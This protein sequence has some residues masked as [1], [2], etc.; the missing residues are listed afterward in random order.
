M[1]WSPHRLVEILASWR[2]TVRR[3]MGQSLG[4]TPAHRQHADGDAG[5]ASY[6]AI[7]SEL[8]AR[9][10]GDEIESARALFD[11]SIRA[12][13]TC[14]ALLAVASAL[15]AVLGT[16]AGSVERT[17]R[18]LAPLGLTMALVTRW[19]VAWAGRIMMPLAAMLLPSVHDQMSAML[20]SAILL[21]GGSDALQTKLLGPFTL[22][23]Q[24]IAAMLVGWLMD[25]GASRRAGCMR[26]PRWCF[27]LLGS[28]VLLVGMAA[29]ERT[30][31]FGTSVNTMRS[32]AVRLILIFLWAA[33]VHQR[34]AH[35]GR[36]GLGDVST[37]FWTAM[38]RWRRR[39]LGRVV[40]MA[41]LAVTTVTLLNGFALPDSL[42][43]GGAN[44]AVRVT[45]ASGT[46]RR[47]EPVMYFWQR[48]GRLLRQA[49]FSVAGRHVFVVDSMSRELAE[50]Y[51][52][53]DAIAPRDGFET[54]KRKRY[55]DQLEELKPWRVG[56]AAE[57]ESALAR[58]ELAATSPRIWLLD[59]H[60]G[61][62]RRV[63]SWGGAA[64]PDGEALYIRE[65]L[66]ISLRSM[67]ET[68]I[69]K[70]EA[71]RPLAM[72]GTAV[73]AA[74]AFVVLWR[75]GGDAA[76]ALW[77]GLWLAGAAMLC[78]MPIVNFVFDSTLGNAANL[79][80]TGRR[81]LKNA[82]ELLYGWSLVLAILTYLGVPAWMAYSNLR[83]PTAQAVAATFWRRRGSGLLSGRMI[84]IGACAA[85]AV[86]GPKLASSPPESILIT[87]A[88]TLAGMFL[89]EAA[90]RKLSPPIAQKDRRLAIVP[91]VIF[92]F[93]AV[94]AIL[95]I[96]S[97][98]TQGTAAPLAIGSGIFA[99]VLFA[100]AAL[101]FFLRHD[102]LRMSAGR[103]LSWVATS[104]AL[105]AIFEIVNSWL[106]WLLDQLGIFLPGASEVASLVIVVALMQPIQRVLESWFLLISSRALR[107]IQERVDQILEQALS[108]PAAH[109]FATLLRGFFT[110]LGVTGYAL[111]LRRGALEFRC[112]INH[113]GVVEES[114]TLSDGLCRRLA[115]SRSVIDLETVHSEWVYFFDQFELH[116]LAT[117]TRGRYLCPVRFGKSLWGLLL[118]DDSAATR[119]IARDA[120]SPTASQ[121]GVAFSKWRQ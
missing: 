108:D 86:A 87:G 121:I 83:P 99:L 88:A 92:L 58:A 55:E 63:G 90:R 11:S 69:A 97:L 116:R 78:A 25:M 14:I 4:A 94:Q 18:D 44:A 13:W 120:F 34:F 8:S 93:A 5:L 53:W 42:A 76:A 91:A 95:Y 38:A 105:P 41:S 39:L 56:S 29:F 50:K 48:Q 60:P 9:L 35:G 31:P 2:V 89:I 61:D 107:K 102:W 19:R 21:T 20:V 40:A 111:W 114:L 36:Y 24:L 106:P 47:S 117:R 26:R 80:A 54:F 51:R 109:D 7:Q 70:L 68:S 74:L 101:V 67:T 71:I 45:V 49:D 104:F 23:L 16:S 6:P 52:I 37:L 3:V 10:S 12:L 1:A 57:F 79:A 96:V 65:P 103:D 17:L 15:S 43:W 98:S 72:F 32:A 30:M 85:A 100:L 46:T 118:L 110:E 77:V 62:A 113:L 66:H 84:L 27:V 112:D 82:A 64:A 33:F 119:G 75:R 81:T 59:R 73:F 28:V 22:L 115:D